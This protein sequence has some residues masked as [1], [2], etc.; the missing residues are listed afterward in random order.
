MAL[1][2]ILFSDL[3]PRTNR[4]AITAGV[5]GPNFETLAIV[6]FAVV[7][8][9]GE[10]T[11]EPAKAGRETETGV[12]DMKADIVEKVVRWRC[13]RAVTKCS[14]RP[15]LSGDKQ[16]CL[17]RLKSGWQGSGEECN[18]GVGCECYR[19]DDARNK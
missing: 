19:Q 12:A 8:R 2:R 1:P 18:C 7:G 4:V 6:H 15:V 16:G 9:W 5:N 3:S 10:H 17:L 13:C 11:G 14:T